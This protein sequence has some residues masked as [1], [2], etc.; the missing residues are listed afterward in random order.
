MQSVNKYMQTRINQI[1]KKLAEVITLL[2]AAR[3][4]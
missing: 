1:M 3:E 2:Q 4:A